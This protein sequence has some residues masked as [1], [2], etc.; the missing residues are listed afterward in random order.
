MSNFVIFAVYCIAAVFCVGI[1]VFIVTLLHKGLKV[2]FNELC[3]REEVA[4]LFVKLTEITL[5]VSA[6]GSAVGATYQETAGKNRLTLIWSAS[7]Q[8]KEC[9]N[10]L[11]I[12][13]IV[14]LTAFLLFFVINRNSGNK[15][16]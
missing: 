13:L 14:F 4:S 5:I 3:N 8:I 1:A 12:P 2:F 7:N 10:S 11:V 6:I 9:L 16:I 15:K